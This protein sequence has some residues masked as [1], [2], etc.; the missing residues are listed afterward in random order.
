MCSYLSYGSYSAF[1]PS[2]DSRA[3]TV[4]KDDSEL[5][6]SHK[7]GAYWDQLQKIADLDESVITEYLAK[8]RLGEPKAEE[9]RKRFL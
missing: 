1:G 7:R 9:T 8:S 3:A 4:S 2:Y 6:F 5:L